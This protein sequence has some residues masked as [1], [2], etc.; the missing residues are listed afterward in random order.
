LLVVSGLEAESLYH[1]VMTTSFDKGLGL[2]VLGTLAVGGLYYGL[3]QQK[4]TTIKAPV[5]KS[6]TNFPPEIKSEL[7]SRVNTFFGVEN[8]KKIESSFIIVS[9]DVV[10]FTLK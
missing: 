3:H 9:I 1:C 2:G 5:S 8:F 4:N 6:A 7:T 10:L